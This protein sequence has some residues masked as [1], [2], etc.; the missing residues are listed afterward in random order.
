MYTLDNGLFKEDDSR[1]VS[2]SCYP[3]VLNKTISISVKDVSVY[4]CIHI[5]NGLHRYFDLSLVA[6]KKRGGR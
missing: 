2:S 1:T 5:L 3:S 4:D 6:I